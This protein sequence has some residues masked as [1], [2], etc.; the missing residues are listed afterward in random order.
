M[1]A[2]KILEGFKSLV[3]VTCQV[4]R[5]GYVSNIHVRTSFRKLFDSL[6]PFFSFYQASEL[7]IG[8][9]VVLSAGNKVPSD[10]RVFES[11]GLKV[12]KSMFTGESEPIK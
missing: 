5:E 10:I 4:V 11:Q 6:I 9:L 8:D 2:S 7:A 3:P 1:A 12:D